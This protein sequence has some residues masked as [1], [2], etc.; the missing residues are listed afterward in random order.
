[1][2]K[3]SKAAR[4]RAE[5]RKAWSRHAEATSLVAHEP[6]IEEAK[7]AYERLDPAL[8]LTLARELAV[9]RGPE[10]T[11]AYRNLVMVASGFRMQRNEA[12]IESRISEPC[13]IFVVRKKP[14]RDR[15]RDPRQ[16][17]PERLLAYAQ[18]GKARVLVAVPTDVQHER[19]Y[20]GAKLQAQNSIMVGSGN[21]RELG[22]LGLLVEVGSG[23]RKQ[24]MGVSAMH[25]LSPGFPPPSVPVAGNEVSLTKSNPTAADV[26]GTTSPIGG[27][28]VAG[29]L[30]SFDVQLFEASDAKRLAAIL[31]HQIAARGLPI[32]KSHTHFD[33]LLMGDPDLSIEFMT[34]SN[35]PKAGANRGQMFATYS[36][37]VGL[38]F[39]INYAPEG[40]VFNIHHQELLRFTILGEPTLDGDSGSAVYLWHRGETLMLL[41][42]HI[43]IKDGFSHVIPVWELLNARNYTGLQ[44]T[45]T[46]IP[47]A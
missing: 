36:G 8:K 29:P 10:L 44:E 25:V 35:H 1:M 23:G 33:Q 26:L 47:L 31:E 20:A 43:S 12:G 5:I 11:L 4:Q 38:G 15:I 13:V 7:V 22:T 28:L 39:P 24:R 46:L 45:D 32:V 37:T 18:V 19:A 30:R 40:Q 16:V 6:L 41:G 17:L 9:T 14:R 2:A 34:A 21:R 3:A 27:R 42:M